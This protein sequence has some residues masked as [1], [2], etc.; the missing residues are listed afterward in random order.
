MGLSAQALGDTV[1]TLVEEFVPTQLQRGDRLVGIR[2]QLPEGE[3]SRPDQLCQLPLFVRGG[4]P[5]RLGDVATV[6]LGRAPGEIQRLNQRQVFIL[7]GNLTEGARLGDAIAETDRILAEFPL[8]KGVILLP[9]TTAE[10]NRALQSSLLTLGTLASFRVFTVRAVQ[11][12]SLTDS[13]VIMP[14]VPLALA[15][16]ILGLFIT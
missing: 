1:Q 7:A 6:D 3:L 4:H 5:L 13:L 11:Y 8:P 2:I 15:G 14:T 10:A 9:S 16:G 12:N